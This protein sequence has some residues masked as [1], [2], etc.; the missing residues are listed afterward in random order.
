MWLKCDT[1]SYFD[2]SYGREA[3]PNGG[4][5][6]FVRTGNNI[7]YA[8]L[9]QTRDMLDIKSTCTI[10]FK[11]QWADG[12]IRQ[13]WCWHRKWRKSQNFN[14]RSVQILRPLTLHKLIRFRQLFH[15][16]IYWRGRNKNKN[17]ETWNAGQFE[18]LFRKGKIFNSKVLL[19]AT[20]NHIVEC[21]QSSL[22]GISWTLSKQS[23][24]TDKGQSEG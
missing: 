6:G 8:L 11:A 21:F 20:V 22:T 18:E 15:I 10:V 2:K 1:L 24:S 12:E 7:S 5:L 16:T 19:T 3:E 9:M 23:N 13:S 4:C 14:V 17:S